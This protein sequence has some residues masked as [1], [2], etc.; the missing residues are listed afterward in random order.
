[1]DYKFK[2]GD[3]VRNQYCGY[4]GKIVYLGDEVNEPDWIYILRDDRKRGC[5]RNGE[6]AMEKRYGVLLKEVSMSKYDELKQRIEGLNNGWTREADDILNEIWFELNCGWQYITFS[7]NSSGKQGDGKSIYSGTIYIHDGAGK[8][9][10]K[11]YTAKFEFHTQCEKNQAFKK[12]LLW[13]LDHS[14]IKKDLVGTE[15]K[16]E[17]EGKVYKA[18][19]V[20]AL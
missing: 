11:D 1:M 12:A 17:I 6:W 14:D 4:E 2:V 9:I 5:G 8:Y 16:V 18:K 3:R 10:Y 7:H 19:I 15:Q 13:L 20:E